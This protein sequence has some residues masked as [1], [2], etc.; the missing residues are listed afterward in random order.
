MA[1]AWVFRAVDCGFGG[2]V[3]CATWIPIALMTFFHTTPALITS[4]VDSP[5]IH[6]F[7]VAQSIK[8]STFSPSPS[9]RPLRPCLLVPAQS[10]Q[11]CQRR[12]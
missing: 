12:S 6:G 4:Q 8:F 7:T 9:L 5:W 11:Y 1:L 3:A 10:A 2:L